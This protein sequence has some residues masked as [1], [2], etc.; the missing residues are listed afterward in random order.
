MSVLTKTLKIMNTL[1]KH[2]KCSNSID[3][4]SYTRRKCMEHFEVLDFG[5]LRITAKEDGRL[6]QEL[7]RQKELTSI[8]ESSKSVWCK[9][10]FSTNYPQF[11]NCRIGRVLMGTEAEDTQA[12]RYRTSEF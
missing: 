8:Y 10:F 4:E 3:A 11:L 2:P 1:E 5:M 9:N 12:Y 6:E 7:E